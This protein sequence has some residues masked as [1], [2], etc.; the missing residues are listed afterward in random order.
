MNSCQWKGIPVFILIALVLLIVAGIIHIVGLATPYWHIEELDRPDI[1]GSGYRNAHFGLWLQCISRTLTT[2]DCTSYEVIKGFLQASRAMEVL[3]I[4]CGSL[5]VVVT[6]LVI[7]LK[8]QKF[9]TL[10]M[11]SA[12]ASAFAGG[13]F[14]IIG[15]IVY[16]VTIDENTIH[17]INNLL[18]RSTVSYSLAL[19]AIS[20]SFCIVSSILSGIG[21]RQ[22]YQ[23][24]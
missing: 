22:M 8:I 6:G 16:G 9:R 13:L 12:V 20:S 14:G 23:D 17:Y 15:V 4:L 7:F 19:C 21:I 1:I 11:I 24:N 5:S 18:Y 2:F 10:L 3:A